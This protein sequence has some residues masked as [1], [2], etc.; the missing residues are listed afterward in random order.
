MVSRAGLFVESV[1]KA[2]NG[3]VERRWAERFQ[4]ALLNAFEFKR[5]SI[6]P[7]MPGQFDYSIGSPERFRYWGTKRE[8][9][10]EFSPFHGFSL[11]MTYRLN[12]ARL[13]EIYQT[14]ILKA[15]GEGRWTEIEGKSHISEPNPTAVVDWALSHLEKSVQAFDSAV[16]SAFE[17][18]QL[19]IHKFGPD[20]VEGVNR[21]WGGDSGWVYF[22]EIRDPGLIGLFSHLD[23][24]REYHLG[25][26]YPH[27]SSIEDTYAVLSAEGADGHWRTVK[28]RRL[29]P[30]EAPAEIAKW[31]RTSIEHQPS[32]LDERK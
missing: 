3:W 8:V 28:T 27:L 13:E 24:P 9:S 26:A 31:I 6:P 32:W 7:G 21:Q 11:L 25:V 2:L 18:Q 17:Q 19:D 10:V 1:I 14:K 16:A 15:N 29:I 23:L 4:D 12:V 30:S 5:T 20:V 22:V